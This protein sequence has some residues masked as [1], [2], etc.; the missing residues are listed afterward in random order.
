[1]LLIA[2]TVTDRLLF[3]CRRA[4]Y[5]EADVYLLD[6][7]LSAV[8]THVG[9]HLF[10]ECIN[11]YLKKKTRILVTHQLQYLKDADYIILINNGVIE[12]QGKF[13]ELL[14]S[15]VDY[16]Q[17]LGGG[18]DGQ[19]DAGKGFGAEA[20]EKTQQLPKLLRQISRASTKVA[21][22]SIKYSANRSKA[23]TVPDDVEEPEETEVQQQLFEASSKGKSER[24]VYAE[25][26]CSGANCLGLFLMSS[27]FI[28]AQAAASGADYWMSFCIFN[29]RV[30]QEEL[31]SY[32]QSPEFQYDLNT[33]KNNASAKESEI[34]LLPVEDLLSTQLCLYIY[35]GIVVFLI[36]I[37]F[38]RSFTFYTVC[39]RS[40]VSLHNDM[41]NSVIR[42]PVRFFDVNPSG[43]L[44]EVSISL[45]QTPALHASVV[46]WSEMLL[47]RL[48]RLPIT[49]IS[50]LVEWTGDHTSPNIIAEEAAALT[51]KSFIFAPSQLTVAKSPR[52]KLC[53]KVV[54]W[55][56]KELQA[57]STNHER[58][59]PQ[60]PSVTVDPLQ[61]GISPSN[62]RKIRDEVTACMDVLLTEHCHG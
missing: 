26:F 53:M 34:F 59:N 27:F 36:V 10:D 38:V 48:T 55:G 32:Y 28:V 3:P 60:L 19:L 20:D 7:P 33:T 9:R 45:K 29:I 24:S 14:A 1:M 4:V 5:N 50:G 39:M 61:D 6:D 18:D 49:G 12:M 22:I 30:T 31:R 37:A 17:L 57:T 62:H 35:T 11:S 44:R 58:V 16:A 13:D 15:D 52:S 47:L 21:A 43:E 51:E 56:K 54:S 25:Y 8:D 40:S 2:D 41:F 23:S 42:T 46:E